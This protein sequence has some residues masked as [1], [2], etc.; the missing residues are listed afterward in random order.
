MIIQANRIVGV[1]WRLLLLQ[2]RFCLIESSFQCYGRLS[3]V[4]KRFKESE[5]TMMLGAGGASTACFGGASDGTAGG[6]LGAETVS[7][8]IGSGEGACAGGSSTSK[9]VGGMFS[10]VAAD[11]ILVEKQR[12][13]LR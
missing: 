3:N 6:G 9:T 8:E 11:M 13:E 10:A 4:Q 12:N 2:K 7:A 1:G 5:L